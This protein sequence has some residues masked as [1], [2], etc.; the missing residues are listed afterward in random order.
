MMRIS[1]DGS[2]LSCLLDCGAAG[3]GLWLDDKRYG[4]W[5]RKTTIAA[6]LRASSSSLMFLPRVFLVIA[7]SILPASMKKRINQD[8]FLVFDISA[9]EPY[10]ELDQIP[11][12]YGGGHPTMN[13]IRPWI[14]A[15][16]IPDGEGIRQLFMAELSGTGFISLLS[17][18]H[19]PATANSPYRCDLHPRW[20]HSGKRVCIDS[21]HE[22]FRAMYEL[23]LSDIL[24]DGVEKLL[25]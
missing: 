5:G 8:C 20:D 12:R 6:S 19:D 18:K 14:A 7:R 15:D 11:V 2:A 16:T 10:T 3:H 9:E 17:L 21:L 25:A 23:N 4:I 1:L 24:G 22:G 13:P